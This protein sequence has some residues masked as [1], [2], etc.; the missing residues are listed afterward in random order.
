MR[1][2]YLWIDF[3]SPPSLPHD[4]G[5]NANALPPTAIPRICRSLDEVEVIKQVLLALMVVEACVM[6]VA[7]LAYLI[8]LLDKVGH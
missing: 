2:K 6:A 3:D 5:D 8:R 1:I 7:A 4:D